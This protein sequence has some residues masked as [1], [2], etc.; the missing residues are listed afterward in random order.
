MHRLF[1]LSL[2]VVLLGIFCSVGL[3]AQNRVQLSGRLVSGEVRVLVK[4]SIYTLNYE[5]DI[6]G[7]L[8]IEPGTTI[9]FNPEGRM[10]VQPGGRLI[11]DGFA[12]A[13]YNPNP[14]SH[15]GTT[16]LPYENVG[17]TRNPYSYIGYSDLRYFLYGTYNHNLNGVVPTD[18]DATIDVSTP[19]DLTINI[20]KYRHIFDV[21]LDTAQRRIIDLVGDGVNYPEPT[22]PQYR[23]P[24]EDAIMFIASK[25]GSAPA[26]DYN[27]Q[28]YPWRR[29]GDLPVNV[30]SQL[31]VFKGQPFTNFSKE[32]GHI[33]VLPGARAA[34]FRNCEFNGLRKDTTVDR[35]PYYV[36]SQF[37]PPLTQTEVN[38]LNRNMIDRSN[39]AGGALSTFSSRTWLI[40]CRFT[41]NMAR[42]RGGALQIMQSPEGFPRPSATPDYYRLDK[43]PNITDKGGELSQINTNNVQPGWSKILAIDY[44]DEDPVN[45]PEPLT[46]YDR[47]YY[48]DARIASYL[49]RIRNLKFD[50][51]FVQL[52]NYKEVIIGT[53]PVRVTR[54][55]TTEFANANQYYGN[56]AFGGAVYVSGESSTF[57]ISPLEGTATGYRTHP[58]EIGFG[59]NN[60]INIHGPGPGYAPTLQTF[61]L[62]D[63]LLFLHNWTNNYQGNVSSLGARGGAMYVGDNTSMIVAGE[64][65]NNYAYTK[66]LQSDSAG[67]NTGYYARGGAIYQSDSR[68]R[69]QVRGGPNRAGGT[70]VDNPTIFYNNW[71]GTGG[72]IFVESITDITD[73]LFFDSDQWEEPKFYLQS[74]I[75]GGSDHYIYTRDYGFNITFRQNRA[76]SYGGAIFTNRNMSVNGAG[77]VT[78]N[79]LIGYGGRYPVAFDS[80]HAGYAGGAVHIRIPFRASSPD[81]E[82]TVQMIRAN[83]TYNKVGENVAEA[84]KPQVRGGG[85]LYV[86]N[87]D[88]NL[89]KSNEFRGNVVYNGNGGAI[90]MVRPNLYNKRFFLTDLDNEER[91]A[92]SAMP[93]YYWPNTSYTSENGVLAYM[94]SA[95]PPDARMLNRFLDNQLIVD[96]QI[97]AAQSGSGTTQI[98]LGTPSTTANLFGVAFLSEDEGYTVGA[99]G[100]IIR[101]TEGGDQWEY[102]PSGTAN[103]LN[104][105]DFL[106]NNVGVIVG[107]NGTVLRTLN[108]GLNWAPVAIN[109][110]P[111]WSIAGINFYS[112]KF[113]GSS[114][115]TGYLVGDDGFIA[116]ITVTLNTVTVDQVESGTIHNLYEVYFNRIH[117]GYAVGH[118][119]LI[120]KLNEDD[121]WDGQISNIYTDLYSVYFT[122][123][124]TG[125]AVG[126]NG[127]L[128]KT[129][130]AG[131]S[132]DRIE[133]GTTIQ[134]N[135]VWFT[136]LHDGYITGNDGLML[137][138]T[139]D[140][141]TWFALDPKT[142]ENLNDIFF[143]TPSVGYTVG[144][145]GFI[146]RTSDAGA[147]WEKKL[148][149][150]LQY[151]D[152][153]R[154]AQESGLPE[155]GVGLG[156]AIYILDSATASRFG[157]LDSTWFN[158]VRILNNFAYSGSAIYSDNFD[159]KLVFNRSLIT[160]NMVDD[161]NDIG[162]F[163]NAITGP[164]IRDLATQTTIIG[165]WASHDLASTCIYGEI[166]G[167]SPA[168]TFSE[169]SN[170]IYNNKSRFLIRLP[171]APNTK[172]VL[173]GTTG[174]G[175]GGTDTLSGNYW[176]KTEANVTLIVYDSCTNCP[177]KK[178]RGG[179]QETFYLD[180]TDLVGGYNYHNTTT[181]EYRLWETKS[182][183]SALRNSF[184]KNGV[185]SYLFEGPFESTLRWDYQPIPLMNKI[186]VDENTP[187]DSSIP[188][189]LLASGRIYDA[190]DKGVEI[191][192]A[193]YARRRMSP[194]EDFAVGIPPELVRYVDN[195]SPYYGK[196]VRCLVRDPF[197]A[198]SLANVTD[199]AY[200]IINSLQTE[201]HPFVGPAHDTLFY[202]PIGYP[203]FLET[204]ANYTGDVNRTNH[205][206]R[207]LNESVFFVI[208]ETTNDYIR[209]NLRQVSEDASHREVFRGRVELIPDSS[210]RIPN[211]TIRRSN[212]GLLNF[213]SN[214]GDPHMLRAVEHNAYNEDKGTLQGRK[215]FNRFDQ[216]GNEPLLYKNRPTMPISNN[217][218]N[219][220]YETYFA[221]ER[222][223]AL[224]V[225]VGDSV[226]VVSRTILWRDGVDTA[227][228]KGF[229][230]R[231]TNST[232]PAEFT[233]DI[234]HLKVD[235]IV[236]YVPSQFPWRNAHG[237]YDT[238]RITNFLHKVFITEDREYPKDVGTYSQPNPQMGIGRDAVGRDHILNITAKDWNNLYDPRAFEIPDD[239]A[240]LRYEA[241]P[242]YPNSGLQ[243]W[244]KYEYIPAGATYVT[245]PMDEANGYLLLRG[246]PTNPYIVP[247]G[248]EVYVTVHNYPPHYR[249]TDSLKEYPDNFDQDY[250]DKFIYLFTPYLHA[251]VYDVSS[252][253]SKARYL[254]QDTI[255][256]GRNFVGEYRFK[257]FVV[258]S[259]PRFLMP[260]DPEQ[261]YP[262]P[263]SAY[264]EDIT[265]T[266][267]SKG[268]QNTELIGTY[269]ASVYPCRTKVDGRLKANLTNRLRFA[270]NF[271]TN[272]ELEDQWADERNWDFRYGRTAYG[273]L[274]IAYRPNAN[275]GDDEAD[276]LIVLDTLVTNPNIYNANTII[277]QARPI[278]M[279]DK[280]LCRY[281]PT[282]DGNSVFADT[283]VDSFGGDFTTRGELNIRVDYDMAL[284]MLTPPNRIN[285]ELALDTV[286][287]VVVNDGHGGI[288][289]IDL[290]L[291]VNVEPIITTATVL[292][293]AKEDIEYNPQ[294]M[295]KSKMIQVKDPNFGQT[296]YFEI[297]YSGS[298]P[299]VDTLW[300]DPCFPDADPT[301]FWYIGDKKT[302]PEWLKI[303]RQSGILYGIP[304]VKDAP[305]DETVTILCWDEDDLVTMQ[306]FS[307]FVDST[308]HRP[309]IEAAP[310]V[311]CVEE[312][313]PYL[314]S[315]KVSDIDLLRGR[316][317]G[318]P[319]ETL[320]FEL[321]D[322]K[323][324][325]T[326]LDP[327]TISGIQDNPEQVVYIRSTDFGAFRD[328][329]GKVTIRI[330][331]TDEAG[332]TDELI[333]R[334]KFSDE[335][336]FV[337]PIRIENNL[338]AYQVL[339]FGTGQG[340]TTGDGLDNEERGTLDA[341]FC[342]F[343]IPPKPYEDAFD[344][345]W[346]IP[347]VNGILRN[348]FPEPVA[349][350]PG[351]LRIYKCIFNS[352]GVAGD[353]S[354]HYPIK[355]SWN[356]N[357]VPSKTDLAKN[358][359]GATWYIKDLQ[360]DG[361]VFGYNMNT[362][363]GASSPDIIRTESD[364]V[365]TLTINRSSVKEFI[366]VHDWTSG[367]GDEYFTLTTGIN[368]VSPN[369]MARTTEIK[370]GIARK[371]NI[372]LEVIDELGKLVSVVAEG[373]YS[374]GSYQLNWDARDI[375]GHELSSGTYT[376]RLVAG[377]V[378]S[379]EKIVILK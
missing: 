168:F 32:W 198:E 115:N 279:D 68:N 320:T 270:V 213:G 328:P 288:G 184:L 283:E 216:L 240:Y 14:F 311:R 109:L 108:G 134:L 265:V 286:L 268:T 150:D 167:P 169:A 143:K 31:I 322:P 333:F 27:L 20:N 135:R 110:L 249:T 192:T 125:Y 28:R 241:Y 13:T 316:Q 305:R 42:H 211:T 130:N 105:I 290:P 261:G 248:E 132:W 355:V 9:E 358:P 75:I 157:R 356:K 131:Y 302:A 164:V 361:N 260:D 180:T 37:T 327:T 346:D 196:Y 353:A 18:V 159:M 6:F 147:N 303:N 378:T 144:D 139:N 90:H 72:A 23:I 186:D 204:E 70:N 113:S 343:E 100:T 33:V 11:A 360:S 36:A 318:D 298:Y 82:R 350:P 212:E 41:C 306:T 218:F 315:I 141:A 107:D 81:M 364:G 292:P 338:R 329:D 341:N 99:G 245:N 95:Y 52:A 281:D 166:Q 203:L 188:D 258:D 66:Y 229:G 94:S 294:L 313:Q 84:L 214:I 30:V 201:F 2:L 117:Q 124:Y 234:Y 58:F 344:A 365:I 123:D 231:V 98:G 39:G 118:R 233:G 162:I 253:L 297:L 199:P 1:R 55:D 280:F 205:D 60:S 195:T 206:L 285:E 272:D 165:N 138:S 209:V 332:L 63:T 193:D 273:F 19:R 92:S 291:L 277:R 252:N 349:D 375:S 191:K 54:D 173:A 121:K 8:I 76:R 296:H 59:V 250:I 278:W 342:E 171:D 300:R 314:D 262:I 266:L 202:H 155:N 220:N 246:R 200:P 257:I 67:S 319:T 50:D 161:R 126:E 377:T 208:N 89:M 129:T 85:A 119:G 96:D 371:S 238:L 230:F 140:G 160:S 151:I 87:A 3:T 304:G 271:N 308:R 25:L 43:N 86:M 351:Q 363:V 337:C 38:F 317:Q 336:N 225:N 312:G 256:Y 57:I 64:F 330:K 40:N 142:T 369:P 215:Y 207:F 227:L 170:S 148:S 101:L 348:I 88:L 51:N 295:D 223:R 69:L 93:F 103:Q 373:E 172:G 228:Q 310:I 345:R 376:A 242:S 74:P 152:V 4:D 111:G 21:V 335:T 154:W 255:D 254:Q 247:G 326:V 340:A 190:Y 5:Y 78:N 267:D 133:T 77:G 48:D 35:L 158:R 17:T 24:F 97:L 263:N 287:T 106:T 65:L 325:N 16:I 22:P 79:T 219:V 61:P 331:V 243:N 174:L 235:T 274:N 114:S 372:R 29:I 269:N 12:R 187:A 49:G 334:V 236:K 222:Y 352:G 177:G 282:T 163:Q 275:P 120:L 194:I 368:S 264:P 379:T 112:V 34:F 221:G 362:G 137:K 354:N 324:S 366:I 217:K 182:E 104:D 284:A 175:F 176:G 178:Y 146:A 244:L 293:A 181:L 301:N 237:V 44:I 210:N 367:V 197:I 149:K 136:G 323:P 321:I 374:P 226:S 370:F 7:T 179:Q 156:G 62:H 15:N 185:H 128:L 116:K 26:D 357:D 127:V 307:I 71:A 347:T 239:Y 102:I 224:P 183:N 46:N 83:F 232:M 299:G 45:Y 259:N 153:R 251:P 309:R 189:I 145:M 80:N 122:N 53:P 47:Q 73:P 91:T 289:K 339:E 276:S 56:L 359:T 10:I